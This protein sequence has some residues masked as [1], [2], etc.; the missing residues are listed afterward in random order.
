MSPHTRHIP[1]AVGL[2]L[3]TAACGA[4]PEPLPASPPLSPVTAAPAASASAF[5]PPPVIA[6]QPT[7]AV[8]TVYPTVDP[9]YPTIAPPAFPYPTYPPTTGTTTAPL[10]K[11]PTPTPAHAAKC[12]G[13]PTK[14]E[15]LALLKLKGGDAIPDKALKVQSGPYC[16]ANWSFTTVEIAGQDADSLEPLMVVATGKGATLDMVAAGTDVCNPQVQASAPAG[17]RVLACGF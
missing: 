6:T 8:P 5:L 15:I 12:V 17:I 13:Q 9:A 10:T 7:A 11:S 2:L 1:L 3:L 16:T 4:P 14:A